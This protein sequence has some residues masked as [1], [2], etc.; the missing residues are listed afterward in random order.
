MM[1]ILVTMAGDGKRFQNTKY[2]NTIKPLIKIKDKTILEWTTDSLPFLKTS[3]END[4]CFAI[5]TE[6]DKNHNLTEFLKK[7]YG[8]QIKIVYF[9][10][11]TRGNLETAF[12][13]VKK[14]FNNSDRELLILDADNFYNGKN[15]LNYRNS[16]IEKEKNNNFGIICTFKPKDKDPKWCFAKINKKNN[17]VVSLHEKEFVENSKP[18]VGVFYFS[19]TSLFLD[20]A[21]KILANNIKIKNEFYMSQSIEN[22]LKNNIIV[23]NLEVQDVCPLGTPEDLEEYSKFL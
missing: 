9:D 18:M 16:L 21:E 23:Y 1:N 3:L 14:I 10:N 17:K 4:L 19:K 5:R 15:F 7:T 12:L 11:L 13:S 8:T 2:E 6:H 20:I 22:M